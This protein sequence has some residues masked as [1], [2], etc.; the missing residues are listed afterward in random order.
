MLATGGLLVVRGDDFAALHSL[1]IPAV[2][3]LVALQVLY[4]VVQS[5]RFH[6]VLVRFA[7]Q[8]IGFWLWLPLFVLGRFLN[9]F[10][11]QA[12]NVYRAVELQRHHG[13][14][15]QRFLV[16]FVNAPWLAMILNFLFGSLAVALLA[17]ATAL[18]GWPLW[19]LLLSAALATTV[20]PLLGLA[21]L[22]LLMRVPVV[23][24]VRFLNWA[25]S[26]FAAMV[27]ITWASLREPAYLLRVSAWTLASFVQASYLLIVGFRALGLEVGVGAA[28]T[29]YV[30]LQLTTY[31]PLTPGNL[32]VQELAFGVLSAGFGA[33]A[34]DGVL[35]SALLRVT[36]VVALVALALPMGGSEA[37]RASRRSGATR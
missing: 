28:V 1:G 35:V 22:P 11:P 27:A 31:V 3:G 37:L 23:S 10:V 6:V 32:G 8:P 30:L 21:V 14:S 33:S 9:L 34:A 12:G 18:S 24:K 15:V 25:Q 36:G 5:G 2:I 26:R 13:I 16:A 4:L 19:L 7:E 29:F 20:G 17:P